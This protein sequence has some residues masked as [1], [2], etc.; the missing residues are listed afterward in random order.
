VSG[1]N[2]LDFAQWMELDLR[3]IDNWSLW[4]D[5]EIVLRTIPAVILGRGAR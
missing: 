5:V 3:Y 2:E 1:R 4:H